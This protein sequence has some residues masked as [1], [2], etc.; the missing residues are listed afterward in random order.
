MTLPA[1]NVA[2]QIEFGKGITSDHAS[3]LSLGFSYHGF[4]KNLAGIRVIGKVAKKAIRENLSH[5]RMASAHGVIK[6]PVGS[7]IHGQT[8]HAHERAHRARMIA[9]Q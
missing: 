6:L 8:Y 9:A 3:N 2:D 4:I 1:A 7:P 5:G